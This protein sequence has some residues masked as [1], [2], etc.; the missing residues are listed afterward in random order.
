MHKIDSIRK[1]YP[2]RGKQPGACYLPFLLKRET[3]N[4]LPPRVLL[5]PSGCF[6]FKYQKHGFRNSKV[7]DDITKT[8]IYITA[9]GAKTE[10][11]RKIIFFPEKE[12]VL[13]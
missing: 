11:I 7:Y 2:E 4:P 13:G 10:S 5:F 12:K 9:A 1:Y 8:D 3:E 6:F